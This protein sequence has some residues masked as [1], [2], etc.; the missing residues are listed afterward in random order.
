[1]EIKLTD[2][3]HASYQ[4]EK[5][6]GF[7]T[8]IVGKRVTVF[9]TIP[10]PIGEIY[11]YIGDVMKGDTFLA[12]EESQECIDQ[13]LITEDEEWFKELTA[14]LTKWKPINDVMEG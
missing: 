10:K 3:V 1:M 13:A 11:M 5:V 6:T 2:W 4:N 14:E 12:P 8:N 9:V 7:V